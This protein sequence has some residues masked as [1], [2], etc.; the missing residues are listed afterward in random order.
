M[1]QE[2]A[3]AE[4]AGAQPLNVNL[5]TIAIKDAFLGTLV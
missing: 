4:K 1:N 5:G 2:P 3:T